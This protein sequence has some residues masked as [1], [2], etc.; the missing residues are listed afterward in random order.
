MNRECLLGRAMQSRSVQ[1]ITDLMIRE[2]FDVQSSPRFNL[3][4][5]VYWFRVPT[6]D[7]GVVVERS[8]GAEGSVQ[9][10]GWHY[11][12]QL[13]P[14]SPSF[15]YCKTDVGFEDDLAWMET[16]GGDAAE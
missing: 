5:R 11:T 7:F 12:I 10:L 16:G 9:A 2:S 14:G 15:T 6:Q 8:Y 13:S 4:D 3:G 1:P